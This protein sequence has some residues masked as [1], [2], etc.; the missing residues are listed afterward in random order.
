LIAAGRVKRL[1][2]FGGAFDPPHLAHVALARAAVQ[3]LGLCELRVFPT[4]QAWHKSRT[5]T[6][7]EHRLAMARVA[8]GDVPRTVVDG[9]ELSRNGP[10]Y[11]VDTLLELQAEQP[12][13]ELF[14]IIGADQAEALH[15]WH[16]GEAILSLATLGVAALA[17]PMPDASPFDTSSLC[18]SR[19][20]DRPSGPWRRGT[21]Y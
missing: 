10:T 4:G 14:L 19:A 13:A 5:L 18:G 17:R 6:S 9:R 3:Q 20:G 8:F 7:A 21:L 1:G 12:D 11:T 16:R 15:S 2:M